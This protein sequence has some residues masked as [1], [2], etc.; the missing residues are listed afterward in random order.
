MSAP[1]FVHLR[2]HSEYSITDGIVRLDDAIRRAAADGMAALALTDL[3][4]LFGMVKFYTGARGAGIKPIVGCDVWVADEDARDPSRDSFARL[5]LLVKNRAGYLRL[6]ELLS[7]AYLVPRRHGR[8]EISRA[9]IANG[10]N[11]GLVA[12]SGAQFGDVGQL[13]AAGKP[14]RA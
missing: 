12:L 4:N 1:R 7:S 3:S 5:L 10:D 14:E 8:A 6:C 9:A 11:G 2:L 13:L